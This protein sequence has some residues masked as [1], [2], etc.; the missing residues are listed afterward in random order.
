MNQ[1]APDLCLKTLTGETV[2]LRH[3]H[4]CTV[5]LSFWVTWCPSCQEDLPAKDR[6]YRALP[7]ESPLRV[8]SV[9]VTGREAEPGK[10][11][12]FVR[13][14]GLALPVLVDKGR[15]AYDAFGLTSVPSTVLI[16]PRGNVR[17]I[18]DETVPFMDVVAKVGKWLD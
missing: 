2:C 6:F 16:D 5:I 10:V 1:P 8:Y 14:Y 15:S 11:E 4:G 12:P 9:N 13:Q 18:Y 17:G 3:L 7:P